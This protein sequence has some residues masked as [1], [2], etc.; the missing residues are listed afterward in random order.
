MC[1][2]IRRVRASR[3]AMDRFRRH[4]ADRFVRLK[5]SALTPAVSPGGGRQF[6][7]IMGSMSTTPAI[8][9]LLARVRALVPEV[10][11][12]YHVDRVALFGSYVHDQQSPASDL[13]I[14]VS[15][16]E[17]PSLLTFIELEDFLSDSLEVKVDLVM[18]D[19]LKPNIGRRIRQDLLPV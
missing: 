8:G 11:A 13:D 18:E 5:P 14:L 16:S 1:R 9:Q 4:R 6:A 15:F 7:C 10:Q 3:R 19:A 17:V 12:R 2:V